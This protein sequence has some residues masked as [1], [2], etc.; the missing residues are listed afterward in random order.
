MAVVLMLRGLEP[1]DWRLGHQTDGSWFIEQRTGPI[2]VPPGALPGQPP[3][4]ASIPVRRLP[5]DRT[6]RQKVIA[7]ASVVRDLGYVNEL[8]ERLIALVDDG[9]TDGV[10]RQAL[11]SSALVAYARTRKPDRRQSYWIS[12][13]LIARCGSDSASL[14]KYLDGLRDKHIAHSIN[15]FEKGDLGVVISREHEVSATVV[16][17]INLMGWEI[18]D[19]R[20]FQQLVVDL[21]KL[22]EASLDELQDQAEAAARAM[23]IETLEKQPS[24]GF[25]PANPSD[26]NVPRPED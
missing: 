5:I 2:P 3:P 21:H 15:A 23:P 4:G 10:L 12:D 19:L 26:V 22:V 25:T 16:T 11:F 13:D 18:K 7:A 17:Y 9:S 8:L 14:D 1:R 20:R 6:L 24:I